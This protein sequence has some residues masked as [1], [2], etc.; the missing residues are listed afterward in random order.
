MKKNYNET[1]ISVSICN[2]LCTNLFCLKRQKS[3]DVDSVDGEKC[4]DLTLLTFLHLKNNHF[5][6]LSLQKQEISALGIRVVPI[7]LCPYWSDSMT[8]LDGLEIRDKAL[9]Y[10]LLPN[11]GLCRCLQNSICYASPYHPLTPLD[12][13]HFHQQPSRISLNAYF[14]LAL[15]RL[16]G[17]LVWLYVDSDVNRVQIPFLM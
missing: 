16:Y 5:V 9:L 11:W 17:E 15:S 12:L 8:A 2:L 13:R 10:N 4:K 7:V 14:Q 3:D 6:Q 1:I